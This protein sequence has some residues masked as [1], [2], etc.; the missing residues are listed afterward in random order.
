[1]EPR[2][3]MLVVVAVRVMQERVQRKLQNASRFFVFRWPAL[4]NGS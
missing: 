2:I 1:M 3:A 4:D